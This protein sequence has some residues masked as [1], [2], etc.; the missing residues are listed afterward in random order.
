MKVSVFGPRFLAQLGRI[1]FVLGRTA[2]R[3][4]N[5]HLAVRPNEYRGCRRSDT[6]VLNESEIHI[7]PC[8][9]NFSANQPIPVHVS[10]RTPRLLKSSRAA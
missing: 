2:N 7:Q 6:R 1:F 9:S 5:L 4:G 8:S 3:R 10:S